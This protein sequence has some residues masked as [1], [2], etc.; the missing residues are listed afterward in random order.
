MMA[1]KGAAGIGLALMLCCLGGAPTGRYDIHT[2]VWPS[3]SLADFAFLLDPPAGRH[4]FLTVD[5]QGRF[6]W[7]TGRRAKFWGVNISRRSVF[8][9]DSTIERAADVLA[10]SGANM[11][12]FEA[13]DAAGGILG[14]S[15]ELDPARL[16]RLDAWI[17]ALADRGIY[18]YLNLL[19]LREFTA[20]DRALGVVAPEHIG[21]AGRPFAMFDPALIRLQREY[22]RR[23]LTHR[24]AYTGLRYVEDPAIAMVEI[25]NE[26]GFFLRRAETERLRRASEARSPYP[27]PRDNRSA[28]RDAIEPRSGHVGGDPLAPYGRELGRRWNLW[29]RSR[30][31]DR[32][33]L[34]RAWG[35]RA[36][37][38]GESPTPGTVR[39]PSLSADPVGAPSRTAGAGRTADYVRF[40]SD[41]QR[42]YFRD[43]RR[44]LR[45]IGLR[46]PV[47]GVTSNEYIADAAS[48]THLDFTAGN[49]F[50]DH[51]T[52]AGK[53]WVGSL[54]FNDVNP[55]R[56]ASANG[57]APWMA[58]LRW[59]RKPAVIR[60]WAQP[61]PNRY[62][63]AAGPETMAYASLQD[64]DGLL[65]FGY[66][67]IPPRSGLPAL[68]DFAHEADPTVWRLFGPCGLAFLRGDVSPGK[69]T[70][71]LAYSQAE[72]A[73]F[74]AT[75]DDRILTAWRDRVTSSLGR[76]TRLSRSARP[77]SPLVS[78]TGQISRHTSEGVLVVAAPRTII[79]SGEIGRRPWSAQAPGQPPWRIATASPVGTLM[80]V[81]LD[82]K[83]LASSQRRLVTMVTEASNTGQRMEPQQG[84]A[85]GRFRI[86]AVGRAP[87]LTG[88]QPSAG[89]LRIEVGGR[90]LLAL[91]MRGGVLEALLEPD[92][93]TLVC[94]TDG[95][96]GSLA[97]RPF[98]TRANVPV[99][100]PYVE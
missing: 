39:I 8:V 99:R 56:S 22:A 34:A 78:S 67:T 94:D 50:F 40:L 5:K 38:A 70:V 16:D 42:G 72:A 86:A 91:D 76:P 62:R 35:R 95:I 1:H 10:R 66:R 98:V 79:V 82:G 3:S 63:A 61:W 47:T 7:P 81:S 25:C 68:S 89:G 29:L 11:V 48:W 73:R 92:A 80:V 77:A 18:T 87:V 43:M 44:Y 28:G 88:G 14:E 13:L 27:L 20:A 23:L 12:R 52:F 58:A 75:I 85:P 15:G 19:D 17:A 6:A 64:L 4:G 2:D 21:R 53:E 51:P 49:R 37:T 83:P 26:S 30:Y 54:F 100:V 65:L 31:R 74:S 96:S 90:P 9:D 33:G 55:L 59:G 84:K 69:T 45:S 97:G 57:S 36:L 24:N 41:I 93:A 46:V 32:A 71:P 60:E